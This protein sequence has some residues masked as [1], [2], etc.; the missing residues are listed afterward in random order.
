M[1][2]KNSRVVTI[3]AL[4][5]AVVLAAYGADNRTKLKLGLNFFS[6]KQ[7][8]EIGRESAKQVER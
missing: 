6:P 7:D 5:L 2:S 3:L 4:T 1:V 8:V